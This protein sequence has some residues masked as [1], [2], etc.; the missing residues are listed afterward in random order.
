METLEISKGRG[1]TPISSYLGGEEEEDIPDLADFEYNENLVETDPVSCLYLLLVFYF[2]R[3]VIGL[4][5]FL[6]L[7][8][9][10][11]HVFCGVVWWH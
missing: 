1:I 4:K 10:A 3:I 5:H 9:Y 6:D 7:C 11:V 8:R 2:P